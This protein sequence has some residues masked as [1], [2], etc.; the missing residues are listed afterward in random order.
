MTTVGTGGGTI[1]PIRNLVFVGKNGVDSP[2]AD[3]S[4]AKP[5]LTIVYALSQIPTVGPTA[6]SPTNRWCVFVAAGRYNEVATINL[7]ADVMIFGTHFMAT[8]IAAPAWGLDASFTPAGDHRSGV[9]NAAISGLATF[10]FN[11][12]ASNEGK[13]Y[14]QNVWL[15]SQVDFTA[16]SPIQQ[17]FL[18]DCFTFANINV[19]GGQFITRNCEFQAPVVFKVGPTLPSSVWIDDHSTYQAGRTLDLTGQG[20]E[21]YTI[22]WFGS[23]DAGPTSITGTVSVSATSDSLPPLASLSLVGAAALVTNDVLIDTSHALDVVA[24]GPL[25]I[26]TVKAN[27]FFIGKATS[28]PGTDPLVLINQDGAQIG[29]SN[30]GV[31]YSTTRANRAQFRGNQFGPNTAAPGITGYKS[32]GAAIGDVAGVN[33][34]GV[35]DGDLLFRI[36]AVGVARDNTSIPLAGLVTIQVPPGG[37]LPASNYVATELEV[38]LVPLEGPINGATVFFKLTSQGV[39]MLRETAA[40]PGALPPL[41]GVEAGLAVTGAGGT[42]VVPNVNVRGAI[43][44]VTTGTRVA[45]TIQPGGAAPTGAVWCSAIVPGVSF[46]IQSMTGDVGVQVYWQLWEGI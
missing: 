46:T 20:A 4:I 33:K 26:G 11:A 22:Q 44:G 13:L 18:D 14:F 43:V 45:L 27:G 42:V 6:P 15:Q 32:R 12:I 5:Y 35:L 39:P 28:P 38:Q 8:R 25:R 34:I 10:N 29:G 23:A 19:N 7:R 9:Q 17:Y 41:A 3:G 40:R 31:Q 16:F 37:S 1:T 30:A 21:T 24:A 36:T 2:A